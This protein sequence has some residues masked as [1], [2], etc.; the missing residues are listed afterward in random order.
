MSYNP[1]AGGS[2]ADGSVTSAKL[3]GDITTAGKAVLTAADKAAQKTWLATAIADVSGLQ[4]ALDGKQAAGSYAASSH[5][6]A[7]SDI[8]NLVSDLAGKAATSHTHDASAITGGTI[9]PARLGSGTANNTTFL[10]GDNTWATPAGGGSV[11]VAKAFLSNTQA[12]STTSPAVMT[13][14]TFTLTPGQTGTFTAILVCTAAATTTGVGAGFRVAQASG[15]NGN[16][17]GSWLGYVNLSSTAA[18]TGLADGDVYNVA[19]NA[20]TYGETLGTATTSGNNAVCVQ[21]VVYNASTNANTTVTFEFR[22]EVAT[23]A[24]TAQIGSGVTAIIG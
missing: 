16:A 20:N 7:Q 24:V 19:A 4:T 5:T 9:D 14:S 2:V 11:T 8:T 22:S 23:S 6:H 17:V 10:R 12:N 3:G 18:A 13:G 15:A 1:N 21:A